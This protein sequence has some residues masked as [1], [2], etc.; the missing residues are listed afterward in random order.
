[1][2]GLASRAYLRRYGKSKVARLVTLGSP[3][4][5]TLLARLGLGP[6]ARQMRIGNPWLVALGAAGAVPLPQGS[7]SIFSHHDNYVYPQETRSRLEG[8]TNVAIG[9]V[10]HLGMA[11]S[12]R[13][14]DSLLQALEPSLELERSGKS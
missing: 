12:P 6:N 9:G 13:V 3:H 11:F 8:A 14:L 1:M 5:G 7:V 2:G 4:Q 10:S